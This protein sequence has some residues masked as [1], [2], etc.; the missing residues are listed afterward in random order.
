[1]SENF[2]VV[3]KQGRIV[4]P[5]CKSTVKTYRQ[6]DMLAAS[7]IVEIVSASDGYGGVSSRR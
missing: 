2:A 4:N 3:E 6:F 7:V 5:V 1:M